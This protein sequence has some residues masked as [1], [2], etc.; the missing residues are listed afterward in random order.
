[1]NGGQSRADYQRYVDQMFNWSTASTSLTAMNANVSSTAGPY[2]VKANGALVG[3]EIQISGQ[4]ATSLAQSGYI[5]LTCTM[6]S[7]INTLIVPFTGFGLLTAP[8]LLGGALE[9]QPWADLNLPVK[10]SVSIS[11]SVIFFY[12]PVT[13]N[14]TVT[15]RFATSGPQAAAS[16]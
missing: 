9:R 13:P 14:I 8:Q 12:S 10:T 6:W 1:M 5:S 2:T 15:G 4:A 3:L 16:D 11:G 7:P